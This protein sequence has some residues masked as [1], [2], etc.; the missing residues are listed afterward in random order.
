MRSWL[1]EELLK[2]FTSPAGGPEEEVKLAIF[3]ARDVPYIATMLAIA[4]STPTLKTL[5]GEW[6]RAI[7]VVSRGEAGKGAE[8]AI[9]LINPR[10]REQHIYTPPALARESEAQESDGQPEPGRKRFLFF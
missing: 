9:T 3:N 8:Q 1:K 5:V 10:H 6:V 7:A 4:N 2:K